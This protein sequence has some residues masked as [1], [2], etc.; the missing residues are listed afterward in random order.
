M[1]YHPIMRS[2]IQF[3]K[4]EVWRDG[5]HCSSE[6]FASFTSS[7][8][9]WPH[10]PPGTWLSEQPPPSSTYLSFNSYAVSPVPTGYTF[11]CQET[12][13]LLEN[14]ASSS[15]KTSAAPQTR[16]KRILPS[17][18]RRGGPGVGSCEVDVMI[19]DTYKRQGA[20]LFCLF[21]GNTPSSSRSLS[22][23]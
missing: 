19:L 9:C 12:W 2:Q 15:S 17:R 4:K 23:S 18:S 7:A 8:H 20:P 22:T 3:P 1:M 10:R 5:H 6:T 21:T 11:R 16:Q 13:T 14:M